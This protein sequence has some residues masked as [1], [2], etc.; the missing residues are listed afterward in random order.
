ME[1][2]DTIVWVKPSHAKEAAPKKVTAKTITDTAV[3]F[4]M[5]N[6]PRKVHIRN[7]MLITQEKT[8]KRIVFEG[9]NILVFWKDG[10]VYFS[11]KNDKKTGINFDL[12]AALYEAKVDEHTAQKVEAGMKCALGL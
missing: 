8:G 11:V 9:L 1:A 12:F 3:H 5:D 7:A 4:V 6:E 2:I 10:F